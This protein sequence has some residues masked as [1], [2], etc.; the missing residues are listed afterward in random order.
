MSNK[1]KGTNRKYQLTDNKYSLDDGRVVYQIQALMD[2]SDVKA[3]DLGGYIESVKDLNYHLEDISWV[4]DESVVAGDGQW[5]SIR[6]E[7]H[8]SFTVGENS[9]VRGKSFVDSAWIYGK[10][11]IIDSTVIGSLTEET[12]IVDS[13]ITNDAKDPGDKMTPAF[14]PIKSS[15]I[16]HNPLVKNMVVRNSS[17]NETDKL[18]HSIVI[19]SLTVNTPIVDSEIY[20]SLVSQSSVKDGSSITKGYLRHVD[21]DNHSIVDNVIMEQGTIANRSEVFDS[22]KVSN[23]NIQSSSLNSMGDTHNTTFTNTHAQES[24]V[25]DSVFVESNIQNSTITKGSEIDHSD[26]R[27]SDIEGST[28][29]DTTLR[30]ST[31]KDD[32]LSS[33]SKID[34]KTA[35]ANEKLGIYLNEKDLHNLSNDLL[36]L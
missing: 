15:E 29:N 23:T 11:E 20:G 12:K 30:S 9:T 27:L 25:Y 6:Q 7:G 28:I 26:I 32:T 24:E 8:D 10:S 21:V 34:Y 35:E 19:H 5:G 4:Y 2:F 17:I 1:V 3:G 13:L 33:E 18:E 36:E 31:V 22:Q 16:R 14:Q